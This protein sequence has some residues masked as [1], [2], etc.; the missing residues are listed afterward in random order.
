MGCGPLATLEASLDDLRHRE[1]AEATR[2]RRE[3]ELRS[4]ED[5]KKWQESM[6][7]LCRKESE[8]LVAIGS[9]F[10]AVS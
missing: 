7:E 3:S 10:I 8:S 4:L 5:H 9:T 1:L 6:A 2:Q